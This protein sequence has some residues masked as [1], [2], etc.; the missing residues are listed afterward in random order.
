M[1]IERFRDEIR[2]GRERGENSG[3]ASTLLKAGHRQVISRISKGSQ[4]ILI[5]NFIITTF[6]CQGG[7]QGRG[8]SARA[9]ALVLPGV[10]PPLGGRGRRGGRCIVR[11]KQGNPSQFFH[12]APCLIHIN[13][14]CNNNMH[15]L[16][17]VCIMCMYVYA[18]VCTLRLC[19][20]NYTYTNIMYVYVQL[21]TYVYG[22]VCVS[23]C[24]SVYMVVQDNFFLALIFDIMSNYINRLRFL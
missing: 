9:F 21:Y 2:E 1:K 5:Y 17:C 24:V 19:M 18:C 7:S 8:I 6:D 3:G 23:I 22:Y 14:H 4:N 20:Y 16:V 11:Q 13:I 15:V 12:Q 10:A